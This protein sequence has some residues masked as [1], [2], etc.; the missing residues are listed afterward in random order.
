MRSTRLNAKCN[1]E[2]VT[3]CMYT[4]LECFS[5]ILYFAGHLVQ[6]HF[7]DDDCLE[8][9]RR[10]GVSS[11]LAVL[12]VLSNHNVRLLASGSFCYRYP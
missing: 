3:V 6:S 2:S 9:V 11:K 8:D 5:G 4:T 10:R 7:D 1:M 12:I